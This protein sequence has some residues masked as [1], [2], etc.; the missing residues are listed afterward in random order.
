M[1][2][3][4]IHDES[5]SPILSFW[6][7]PKDFFSQILSFVWKWYNK[8]SEAKQVIKPWP[9]RSKPKQT[10]RNPLFEMG[11]CGMCASGVLIVLQEWQ[12][13]SNKRYAYKN[14]I[15]YSTGVK[16]CPVPESE[17]HRADLTL[18]VKLNGTHPRFR[19][20]SFT[21]CI[22]VE[23]GRLCHGG[24]ANSSHQSMSPQGIRC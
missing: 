16:A 23:T 4:T 10:A 21:L 20:H 1:I 5:K 19:S 14:D 18:V 3:I 11:H 15:D 8:D 9:N 12:S 22:S 13:G 7:K 6:Q 2:C 17:R 24:L